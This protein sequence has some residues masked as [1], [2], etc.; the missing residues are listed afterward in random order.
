M[1]IEERMSTIMNDRSQVALIAEQ[2]GSSL[3]P[4]TNTHYNRFTIESRSSSKT[5]VVSQRRGGVNDGRWECA[6]PGWCNY[7]RHDAQ[8][9]EHRRCYHL[10]DLLSKLAALNTTEALLPAV[11][12]MLDAARTQYLD[13]GA[14]KPVRAHR[15]TF[16]RQLDL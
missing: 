6:C 11:R 1:G 7:P 4:D 2:I 16:T 8:G 10:T 3:M 9:V 13:L 5:Y 14:A 12:K 15:E